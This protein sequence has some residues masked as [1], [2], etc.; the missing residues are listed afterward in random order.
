MTTRRSSEGDSRAS[1]ATL[2][3]IVVVIATLF[4]PAITASQ[5][6]A[7][8]P[9]FKY[10]L[11]EGFRG[12]ACVDFG[13]E[14]APSLSRDQEMYLI[15]P[16]N[17]V[18]IRTSSFPSL[19][20]PPL[21]SELIQVVNG[22]PLRVEFNEIQQRGEY[23]TK[24]PI[25]RYCLFF[26]S[27]AAAA[28]FQRPPTLTE[29]RLGTNPVLQHFE[30]SKG[31]LC[32]F[33][34]TSR[35]CLAAKDVTGRRVGDSIR[36]TLGDR[37]AVVAGPCNAFDGIVVRYDADWAVQTHSS[38]RGP[39]FAFAEV[40]REIGG[41]G[42]QALATWSNTEGGSADA[43]AERFGRELAALLRQAASSTCGR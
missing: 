31:E 13:V 12:W 36:R 22:K 10:V 25:A 34:A 28:A 33:R 40:R 23:D 24:N 32:D 11:A 29:S 43:V 2:M 14:G 4:H 15:E 7:E 27:A 5:S 3:L 16:Q 39:R 26:G 35:L 41:K 20:T 1:A 37:I 8:V 38:S 6:G 18:I 30:F 9:R 17:D 21:P 19:A 42:T